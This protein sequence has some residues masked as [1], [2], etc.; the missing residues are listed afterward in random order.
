MGVFSTRKDSE[1]QRAVSDIVSVTSKS[2]LSGNFPDTECSFFTISENHQ[3]A[4]EK[5]DM[6]SMVA[7]SERGK[8]SLMRQDSTL[9]IDWIELEED[10]AD[11]ELLVDH[12]THLWETDPRSVIESSGRL[13]DR[14][15]CR[16]ISDEM[17]LDRA[18]LQRICIARKYQLEKATNLFFE[19]VRFR[20]RWKPKGIQPCD[21]PNALPCE[22]QYVLI[23]L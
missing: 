17:I 2:I 13:V 23:L 10:R 8:P 20:A 4:T 5:N 15:E 21:I 9:S 19:Q 16:R 14:E 1:N 22:C 6:P 7:S 3:T 18:Q 11:I 12:V